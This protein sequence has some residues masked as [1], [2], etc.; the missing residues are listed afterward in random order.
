VFEEDLVEEL[1]PGRFLVGGTITQTNLNS[2]SSWFEDVTKVEQ[3]VRWEVLDR[4]RGKVVLRQA[5]QGYAEAD[6]VNNPV[7]SYEAIR[8]SF[9]TFLQEPKFQRLIQSPTATQATVSSRSEPYEIAAIASSAHIL[10][11]EQLV[12]QVVP[13]IVQIRTP[14][15]RGTGFLLNAPGLILT[16]QHVVGSALSVKVDLYDGSTHTGRVLRRDANTDAALVRLEG[17]IPEVAGLPL[18]YTNAIRVG[19]PVVAIGNPLSLS[20]TVTRGIVSGFRRNQSRQMIQMDAAVN[21][22]NSGGPLFN[23]HGAVIGIVTQKITTEGVEGLGFALPISEVL[24]KLNVTVKAP[25]N[26]RVDGCGNPAIA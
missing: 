18:C 21:P 24:Q 4:D 11:T 5:T 12:G 10:P 8:A 25:E 19:E 3:T 14:A 26:K 1:E 6:G 17:D 7:A 15:G 2:Y 9:Q 23:Q 20:N 13:S 16:N 22:G